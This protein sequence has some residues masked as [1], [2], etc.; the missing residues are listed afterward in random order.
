MGCVTL[1]RS[2]DISESHLPHCKMVQ[3]GHTFQGQ[4]DLDA[5]K[6]AVPIAYCL[7]LL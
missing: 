6:S 4:R 1:C 3:G 7:G 2:H 5:E